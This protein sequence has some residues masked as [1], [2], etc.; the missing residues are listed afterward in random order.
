MSEGNPS[1]R[2]FL[3]GGIATLA[4]LATPKVADDK[5]SRDISNPDD[6]FKKINLPPENVPEFIKSAKARV[7]YL[8]GDKGTDIK[9]NL[10]NTELRSLVIK[11]IDSFKPQYL[12]GTVWKNLKELFI[13]IMVQES[14]F[15][16]EIKSSNKQAVGL[17][18]ITQIALD[19]LAREFKVPVPNLSQLRNPA[20]STKIMLQIFDKSLYRRI[21]KPADSL[22]KSFGLNNS[23]ADIFTTLCL[24]N[25]YNAGSGTMSKLIA[26]TQRINTNTVEVPKLSEEIN[27][28]KHHRKGG[29]L[30]DLLR[31]V[32][33]ATY[34]S[35]RHQYGDDAQAYVQNV[36]AA[37]KFVSDEKIV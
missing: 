34:K 31:K 25:A 7:E 15:N 29:A 33:M 24:V 36:L 19:D 2:G 37:A 6:L 27:E 21:G 4:I 30:F 26:L 16:P 8:R 18:Q 10:K 22:A 23:E 3:R 35:L 28:V 14:R 9:E 5:L 12:P 17:C 1:R 32:G 13:G 11:E 20:L